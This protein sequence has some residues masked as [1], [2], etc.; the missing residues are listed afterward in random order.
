MLRQVAVLLYEEKIGYLR[1]DNEGFTFEYLPDYQG[2]PLSLSFPTAKR[3]FKS[4]SLFP[5][6]SSLAPEGWL[7]ARFSE[8]QK[9]DEKDLLGILIQNGENLIGAVRL[10]REEE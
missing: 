4:P 3:I 1:Q 9:I 7:K 10:V 2:I 6:F 8:L 5:Y